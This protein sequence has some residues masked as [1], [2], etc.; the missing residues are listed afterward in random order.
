MT[1][2]NIEKTPGAYDSK[3]F[4]TV[5]NQLNFATI[6]WHHKAIFRPIGVKQ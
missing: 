5:I 3:G 2:D 1:T 6:K 4:M